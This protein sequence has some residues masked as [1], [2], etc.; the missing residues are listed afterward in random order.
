M[1]KKPSTLT[2]FNILFLLFFIEVS[3][4]GSGQILSVNNISLRMFIFGLAL[5][6]T[7]F[8]I[9]LFAKINFVFFSVV[10]IVAFYLSFFFL[11]GIVNGGELSFIWEDVKPLMYFFLVY[12]IYI[13]VDTV[14]KIEKI[15]VIYIYVSLFMAVTYIGLLVSIKFIGLD[16]DL[17]YI[18]LS[19][20]SDDFIFRGAAENPQF[21]YKGFLYLCIG[22]ILIIFYKTKLLFKVIFFSLVLYAIY[23]TGTRGFILSLFAVL[24]V[25]LLFFSK[26]NNLKL[27]YYA[28]TVVMLILAFI[29]MDS[30]IETFYKEGS[31]D[32]RI[33]QI[34]QVYN[35]TSLSSFFWG[36][37]FGIGVPVSPVHMEIA[38]LEIFHKNGLLGLL[39]WFVLFLYFVVAYFTFNS[40]QRKIFIPFLLCVV[41]VYIQSFTNPFLNNPIGISFLM[42]SFV[43][44]YRLRKSEL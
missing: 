35:L 21:F 8:Y 13:N 43:V 26:T 34:L 39:V 24:L 5:F 15:K 25:Y 19:G 17:I 32:K 4:L 27:T 37:G 33:L 1:E 44:A 11:L 38:F 30:I 42:V 3:L 16:F 28:V 6:Y 10:F 2:S 18:F 23:A 14:E 36:H 41:F 9:L 20:L 7:I 22:L 31:D 29:F 40:N 12:F